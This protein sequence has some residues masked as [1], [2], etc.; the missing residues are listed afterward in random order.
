VGRCTD[1][2][3]RTKTNQYFRPK[4]YRSKE[5]MWD[6]LSNSAKSLPSMLP[7]LIK[8]SIKLIGKTALL[9]KLI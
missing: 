4:K 2:N 5:G 1:P 6:I 3:R 9:C 7:K 8:T